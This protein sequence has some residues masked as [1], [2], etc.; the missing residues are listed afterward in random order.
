MV[1]ALHGAGLEVI[2]DVVFNHTAESD[3][4]GPTLCHRGLDNP[5]Y[6]RLDPDDPG[7]Y[8][9]TTGCGNSL[10][11]ADPVGL[12]LIMDSLRYWLTEMRVDGFRFDLAPTLAR[13]NGGFDRRAA[14]FDLVAQDPVVSQAK[15]IAEPW[16]VGQADSYDIGRFP[17][18]VERV[19][20]PLPRHDAR[21]LAQP[22]RAC[23]ASSPPASAGSSD[24]YGDA[25]RRPTASVNLITV[26][27]GFTL[28]RPGLLR[29]Q[30]Q[31]GERRGQPGRHRRQPLLE[32]RRRGPD[33]RPDVLAL[34][35]RQQRALLTTL[36]L[37]FGVPLLLGGDELGRTQQGNN[38]AYCQDNE[39]DLVRLVGRRR[40]PAGV[41]PHADRAAAART[42]CSGAGGSCPASTAAAL[43][44]VHAGR[45]GHDVPR[46]G[47]TPAPAASPST[48]T[49]SDAPDR[50]DDGSA[51]ARR[52]L[53]RARQRLV[54]AADLHDPRPRRFAAR[55][56][57]ELDSYDPAAM[58]GA[59]PL[60]GGDALAVGPGSVVVLRSPR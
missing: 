17:P 57:A 9:D 45:H 37:S 11:A 16:D 43:R 47:P 25:G 31:R 12:Q 49:A 34:R 24:L 44:L 27:D 26:H 58:D 53:P 6:Y 8:V 51:A 32:L 7:R 48:W 23:S 3:H 60:A 46:T 28:R 18:A 14:F 22:R 42:R 39:L 10:N 52:R 40:G 13:E 1:D 4:L 21:L 30:A 36:L 29:R 5:A 15:L 54:G 2:L 19:E 35:A 50:A 38:N 56:S 20:R 41:H 59:Q 55:G 33:R